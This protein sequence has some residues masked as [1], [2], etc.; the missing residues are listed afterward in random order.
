MPYK[1]EP[2]Q[3]QFSPANAV[4]MPTIAA[5]LALTAA[6]VEEDATGAT[7]FTPEVIGTAALPL[8]ESEEVALL[9]DE[10][11][12]IGPTWTCTRMPGTSGR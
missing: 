5:L 9:A 4:W 3:R 2:S 8:S 10:R 12:T 6:C 11:T 1:T 7:I